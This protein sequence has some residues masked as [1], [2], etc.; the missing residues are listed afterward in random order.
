MLPTV[1]DRV[2][3]APV[4]M[5]A[6]EGA[7]WHRQSTGGM[8]EDWLLYDSALHQVGSEKLHRTKEQT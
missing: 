5:R 4:Q 7:L 3:S 8:A 1:S 2:V 6:P